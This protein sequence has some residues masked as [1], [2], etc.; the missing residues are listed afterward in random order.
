[1]LPL[2]DGTCGGQFSLNL[3]GRKGRRRRGEKNK[4]IP[5]INPLSGGGRLVRDQVH[6]MKE[7][8]VRVTKETCK[9][10]L[11]KSPSLVKDEESEVPEEQVLM[12][13]VQQRLLQTKLVQQSL[14]SDVSEITET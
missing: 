12:R 8:K 7:T 13:L 6:P 14:E 1:M 4:I 10:S 3:C 9:D 2:S 5:N 11:E